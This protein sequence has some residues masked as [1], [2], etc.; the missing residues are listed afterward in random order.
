M[1]PRGYL[2]GLIAAIAI[3]GAPDVA[4]ADIGPAPLTLLIACPA[5]TTCTPLAIDAAGRLV[6]YSVV[7]TS[8]AGGQLIVHDALT[9]ADGA[10]AQSTGGRFSN[11]RITDDGRFVLYYD[12]SSSS[13]PLVNHAYETS[14]GTTMDLPGVEVAGVSYFPNA[15]SRDLRYVLYSVFRDIFLSAIERLVVYDRQL[16]AAHEIP[17]NRRTPVIQPRLSPDGRSVSYASLAGGTWVFDWSNGRETSLASSFRNFGAAQTIGVG[18]APFTSNGQ[19]AIA[20]GTAYETATG[21]AVARSP[22]GA[23][24]PNGQYVVYRCSEDPRDPAFC[25]YDQLTTLTSR[26]PSVGVP[27]QQFIVDGAVVDDLGRVVYYGLSSGGDIYMTCG[28]SF[29]PPPL[30]ASTN[31]GATLTVRLTVSSGQGCDWTAQSNVPWITI[32]SPASGTGTADITYVVSTNATGVARTGTL[33]IGGQT[34]AISQGQNPNAPPGAPVS[35]R[36]AI[37][38]ALGS[39]IWNPPVDGGP[40]ISYIIEGGSLPGAADQFRM[41][42]GD[43][44]TSASYSYISAPAV[45]VRV[46]AANQ[47]GESLASNELVFVSGSG[48]GR[49]CIFPPD[50]PPGFV[51]DVNGSTV[52]LRWGATIP[53]A[54]SS[55]VIEAGSVS[56]LANLANFMTGGTATSLVVPGV[57]PGAYVARVRAVDVCGEGPASNEIVLTVR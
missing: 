53:F 15:A 46:K 48:T 27:I 29:V 1:A 45:F 39:L 35:L 40:V 3:A 5:G 17:L 19:Y 2:T 33:T 55:Y 23:I 20:A 24:S 57:A 34:F 26:L 11:V 4:A 13:A 6:V 8:Q 25:V 37:P 9:N 44:T 10:V 14:T 18:V 22:R 12:G 16:G 30:I 28:S 38:D 21:R 51:A 43:A 52:S 50:A 41:I 54:R 47:F 32:T 49:P 7:P 56:G 36:S 31:L 42:T